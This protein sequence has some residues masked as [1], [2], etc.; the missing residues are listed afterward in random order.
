[1]VSEKLLHTQVKYIILVFLVVLNIGSGFLLARSD[2]VPALILF[3]AGL[4]AAW[5]I[6]QLYEGTNQAVLYL[7]NALR[8]DDTSVQFPGGLHNRSLERLY[9]S[10]NQLNLYYQ[11]IKVQHASNEKYYRTLIRHS[12]TGLL[13][14]NSDDRVELINKVACQYAGI[15][16]DSSSPD[17]LRIRN[18]M[19]HEAACK[20]RP[21][22]DTLYKHMLGNDLQLL[23]FRATLLR[24]NKATVKII[25]I[26]DIRQ[27]LEAK[28]LE[29]YRKLISVL[30][31]EIM[32]LMS[33]LTSVSKALVSL[34]H[35]GH[36]PIGLEEMDDQT[37]KATLKGLQVIDEQS[38]G[39]LSFI[40][41]YRK[42]SRIPVPLVKQFDV[43]EW[44][45]QIRIVYGDKMKQNHITFSLEHDR[46]VKT[47]LADKSL[48]NQV[49]INLLNNAIDAVLENTGERRVG[50]EVLPA[51]RNRTRIKV[52]DNG[53]AIPPELQE[54]IFVPFFTTKTNGS[55]IGLSIS[56]EIIRLHKGSLIVVSAKNKNTEFILEL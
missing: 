51:P 12:A 44:I 4:F 15:S 38:N 13:V 31:H 24:R 18:P 30:T 9:N 45:E 37:L 53:P 27:E 35:R 56:Q 6:L 16:P 40:E 1:M 17:L 22:E 42:I 2:Y 28:E 48:L 33:P 47:I 7:I 34:Y 21:G 55:G 25:S 52:V 26:Q 5:L 19:F 41:N 20:L 23:S 49:I 14:M 32:N 39:I 11:N 29:S 46:Q 36:Q 3:A 54:K 10:M 43:G 8:N 50:I